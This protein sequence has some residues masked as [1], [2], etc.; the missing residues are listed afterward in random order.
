MKAFSDV[1]F[2][3]D[4]SLSLFLGKKQKLFHRH[5]VNQE[6]DLESKTGER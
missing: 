5:G 4:T 6:L 2:S 1:Q 3:K